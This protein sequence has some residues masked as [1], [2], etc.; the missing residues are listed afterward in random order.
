MNI[1]WIAISKDGWIYWQ[2]WHG[3][4]FEFCLAGEVKNA[5]S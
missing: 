4:V 3:R 5:A 2:D 1:N